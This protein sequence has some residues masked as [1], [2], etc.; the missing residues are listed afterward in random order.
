[1]VPPLQP[2]VRMRPRPAQRLLAFLAALLLV[3]LSACAGGSTATEPLPP[4]PSTSSLAPTTTPVDYSGVAL[5]AVAA[6]RPTTTTSIPVTSGTATL[7]GT[8]LGPDGAP[9]EGATVRVERL[10]G[11]GW[12]TLDVP[13][14]AGGAWAVLHARGGRYRVRAWRAPDLAEVK[15]ALV[16]LGANETGTVDM[17]LQRY[18][19]TTPTPAIAPSKPIVGQPANLVVQITSRS[20]DANG[21]VQGVPI[22]AATVSL[23][24]GQGWTVG[25]PDGVTDASG[26]ARWQLVCAA[27]G[28]QPLRLVV[29]SAEQFDLALPACV[30]APAPPAPSST[31][32]GATTTTKPG[33]TTTTTR[34]PLLTT[35]TTTAT[36]T[37]TTTTRPGGGGRPRP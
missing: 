18:F 11:D 24:G 8:V 20:V 33:A 29:N 27:V 12:G 32:A 5:P 7:K 10:V 31:V 15:P 22:A 2:P 21:I 26:R 34:A 3:G 30:E 6:A 4:P 1:M 9:V 14:G 13:T 28:A 35:T 25:Q 19:G 17:T 37:T 23:A 36:T 16:F